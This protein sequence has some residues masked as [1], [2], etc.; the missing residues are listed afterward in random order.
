MNNLPTPKP[1]AEKNVWV[2]TGLSGEI[3][4]DKDNCSGRKLREVDRA[5][6]SGDEALIKLMNIEGYELFPFS[7]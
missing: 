4:Y 1:T 7:F 3:H 5:F 2:H 6:A